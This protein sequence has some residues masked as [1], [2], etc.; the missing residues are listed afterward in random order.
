[1]VYS[2]IKY[3]INIIQSNMYMYF[4][5]TNIINLHNINNKLISSYPYTHTHICINI[6]IY[7]LSIS[8]LNFPRYNIPKH[9][10]LHNQTS[11]RILTAHLITLTEIVATESKHKHKGDGPENMR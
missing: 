4:K 8:K 10:K 6:H 3:S 2:L 1:M 9:T 7:I 5:L 11:L